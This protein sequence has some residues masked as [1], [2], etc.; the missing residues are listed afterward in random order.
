M[1]QLSSIDPA[2]PL[3]EALQMLLAGREDIRVRRHYSHGQ[4]TV[5]ADPELLRQ[6]WMNLIRNALE[7]MGPEGGS[8]RVG[9]LRDEECLVLYLQDSGPGIPVEK[10]ARL[11]EPFFTTKPQGSGLGLTIAGTL[12]EANGAFL[13]LMPEPPD[14]ASEH[15]ACFALRMAC[16]Q[17]ES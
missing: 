13:E 4:H 12:A 7:A 11:F 10:M 5:Q 2:A 17:G 6:L 3:E 9:S 8:F 1:P 16:P 14:G 15:G